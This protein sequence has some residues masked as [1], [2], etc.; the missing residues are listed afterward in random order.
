MLR[1]RAEQMGI[2]EAERRE[3]FVERAARYLGELGPAGVGPEARRAT[4]ATAWDKALLYGVHNEHDVLRLV[5]LCHL[6]GADFDADPARPWV[7]E[8]LADP[9][10][11]AAKRVS[12]LWAR[13][14]AE[15]TR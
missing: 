6:F 7:R 13:M 1:I 11:S 10:R 2:F 9:A 14:R 4:A 8:V 5:A 3:R 15:G 12:T